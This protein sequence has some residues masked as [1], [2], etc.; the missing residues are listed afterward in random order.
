MLKGKSV[1]IWFLFPLP[2][3]PGLTVVNILARDQADA[4]KEPVTMENLVN[5][6]VDESLAMLRRKPSIRD[7]KKVRLFLFLQLSL[8][9]SVSLNR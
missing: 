9:A 3:L 8:V 2:A 5:E 1:F 4:V 6:N 7:R